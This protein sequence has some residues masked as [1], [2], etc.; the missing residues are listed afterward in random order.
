MRLDRE[1]LTQLLREALDAEASDIHL[2]ANS[3]PAL[4]IGQELVAMAHP[5]LQG[6]DTERAAG[7]L[8]R[9]ADV[10]QPL[11]S[12]K[13]TRF[14]MAAPSLGRLRVCIF[15]QRGELGILM[16]PLPN[17]A[18]SLQGLGVPIDEARCLNHSGV[19][20]VSG[21]RRQHLVSA[22][23]DGY[24][25]TTHGHVLMLEAPILA[26]HKDA[27]AQVSQREIG[28]DTATWKSGINGALQ[29]DVDVLVL[30]EQPGLDERESLVRAAEEGSSV[31]IA[32]PA[33]IPTLAVEAFLDG[34]V[35]ERRQRL[36]VR[37]SAVLQASIG[38]G[39]NGFVRSE[40]SGLL[41]QSCAA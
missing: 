35:G 41:D 21:K 26:F 10:D 5:A 34:F 20:L 28:R 2:K 1:G 32:V 4:R 29:Q 37:L 16:R 40:S 17:Q 11:S 38:L 24:N 23:V 8:L 25:H 3:R 7:V 22:L 33:A 6:T 36:E 9:M 31:V 27:C 13:E 19:V 30:N 39:R 15:R 12:L 18:P 14:V